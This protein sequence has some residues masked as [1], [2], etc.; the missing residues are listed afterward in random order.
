MRLVTLGTRFVSDVSLFRFQLGEGVVLPPGSSLA[1][2]TLTTVAQAMAIVAANLLEIDQ[3][4]LGAEFRT[5]QTPRGSQGLDVD[6]YLYDTTPGGAGFVTAAAGDPERLLLQALELLAGCTCS[7]SCYRCLRSWSNR[8]LHP[9]LDRFLGVSFLRHILNKESRPLLDANREENL[10]TVLTRDLQDSGYCEGCCQ[11]PG[12]P[13]QYVRRFDPENAGA[14]RSLQELNIHEEQF[15]LWFGQPGW[16]SLL[17]VDPLP[18]T[19]SGLWSWQ[20]AELAH[21]GAQFTPNET[22]IQVVSPRPGDFFQWPP[23]AGSGRWQ[24]PVGLPDGIYLAAQPGHNAYHWRPLLVE[25]REDVGRSVFLDGGSA[26][27]SHWELFRWLLLARGTAYAEREQIQAD[28]RNASLQFTFPAPC[29]MRRAAKL[30]G[31][32]L[33]G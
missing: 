4:N 9:D 32:S 33:G 8:F 3:A 2:I 20:V 19:L 17:T 26:Q 7:E 27:H 28:H 14:V 29:Q 16:Q 24:P 1:R 21:H 11:A 18:D 13:L 12:H 23:E 31:E 22:A 25:L 6:V 10:L 15:D 5:A 30:F